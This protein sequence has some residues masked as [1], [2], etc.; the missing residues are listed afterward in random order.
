MYEDLVVDF[1]AHLKRGI[2][3]QQ[4]P[5]GADYLVVE[6]GSLAASDSAK[7][8]VDINFCF[9]FFITYLPPDIVLAS[10]PRH[11]AILAVKHRF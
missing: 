8:I 6:L 5:V 9:F 10:R 2:G 3:L 11:F 7:R 1:V 4:V